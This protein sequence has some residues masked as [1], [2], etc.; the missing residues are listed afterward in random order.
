MKNL[1]DIYRSLMHLVKIPMKHSEELKEIG[2]DIDEVIEKISKLQPDLQFESAIL[3]AKSMQK[4]G[5]IK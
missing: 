5:L 3:F 4:Y 2:L 1:N